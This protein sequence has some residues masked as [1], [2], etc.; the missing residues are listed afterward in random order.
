MRLVTLNIH[1]L[2]EEN[3][4][5]KQ[6]VFVE[7]MKKMQPDV[8][9]LQEVN[10]LMDEKEE[11][12]PA[13]YHPVTDIPLKKGN[14]A[15]AI[16]RL[17]KEA[18]LDYEFSWLPAK[19]GYGKYDEGLAIFT[20]QK[21]EKAGSLLLSRKDDYQDYRTRKALSLTTQ[22]STFVCVHMGWWNDEKEPFAPQ[23]AKLE[24]AM[25]DKK[26]VFLLGDFNADADVKD[27]G[28]DLIKASGYTDLYETAIK[29]DDGYTVTAAIDG[30]KDTPQ[31]NRRIDYIFSKQ[32]IVPKEM[33]TIFNGVKE[34][35]ISDHHGL[36][37][38]I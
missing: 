33:R 28:H 10:Q 38:E 9:A 1:S 11:M 19:V 31:K 16:D 25:K 35:I 29:K 36:F 27:E 3:M 6:K 21:M 37:V 20:K 34:E 15:L 4:D 13:N 12:A 18:G 8:I 32:K 22:D 14:H 23:W 7:A 2:Q 24:E 26:D 17:M 30:W 5:R